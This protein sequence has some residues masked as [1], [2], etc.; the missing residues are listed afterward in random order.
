LDSLLLKGEPDKIVDPLKESVR[1]VKLHVEGIDQFDQ[2]PSIG[3]HLRF[4]SLSRAIALVHQSGRKLPKRE[5]D[6][7]DPSQIW[8]VK[9]WIKH[10]LDPGWDDGLYCKC[11]TDFRNARTREKGEIVVDCVNDGSLAMGHPVRSY[12]EVFDVKRTGSNDGNQLV[13]VE[14]HFADG[15]PYRFRRKIGPHG[16]RLTQEELD[17]LRI[18][19]SYRAYRASPSSGPTSI[20]DD[21]WRKMLF[22]KRRKGGLDLVDLSL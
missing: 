22:F 8:R 10:P 17:E 20:S 9:N 2:V 4:I 6:A 5:R 16:T 1:I 21:N 3:R 12:F 7:L 13:F 14:Y 11:H 18:H 19:P 15:E